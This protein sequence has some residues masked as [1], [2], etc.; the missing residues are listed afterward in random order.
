MCHWCWRTFRAKS[1]EQIVSSSFHVGAIEANAQSNIWIR[2]QKQLKLIC[3]FSS[4]PIKWYYIDVY[5]YN[6]RSLSRK[7]KKK[8]RVQLAFL[9]FWLA[10]TDCNIYINVFSFLF[11]SP[12]GFFLIKTQH[13]RRTKLFHLF[14]FFLPLVRVQ[15]FIIRVYT[16]AAAL[17]MFSQ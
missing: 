2:Q 14:F 15:S 12:A 13:K 10:S 6:S 4:F 11:F 7:R 17:T 5:I 16:G 9:Y 1:V 8:K 3:F